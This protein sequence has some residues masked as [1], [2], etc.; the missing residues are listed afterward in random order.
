LVP[1]LLPN[2]RLARH[3][4][5]RTRVWHVELLDAIRDSRL[6]LLVLRPQTLF[7]VPPLVEVVDGF[8]LGLE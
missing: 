6:K 8:D 2:R 7:R 4:P 1:G 5:V 3:R